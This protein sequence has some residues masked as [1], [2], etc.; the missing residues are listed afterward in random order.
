VGSPVQLNSREAVDVE[1]ERQQP[2]V[3]PDKPVVVIEASKAWVPLNL[4]NLWAYRELV[5][6]LMWRDVKVRY[7][8][9]ILGAAWAVMQPLITTLI[10][11]V[12]FGRWAGIPSDNV[13]YPMF[14]YS[15]LL[16]WTFFS[17]AVMSAGNSLIGNANLITKVYFPRMIIP[18]AA[19]GSGLVDLAIAFSIQI[20]LMVYYKVHLSWNIVLLPLIIL[21]MTLLAL[22]VGMW[23]AALN[24]KYRDVRYALPFVIQIWMFLTPIIYSASMI[25]EQWRWTLRLNPLASIIEA[26]RACLVGQPIRWI[27]LAAAAAASVVIVILA[28]YM[29][30]RMEKS[31]AELV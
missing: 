31:F 30:R 29:F 9:T 15:G 20:A 11:T 28:S 6:F 26:Y 27:A 3:L 2:L 4:L 12:L 16:A 21:M 23:T 14:V 25:P 17:N 24:V 22:G 18:A 19:V 13:P 7:K 1:R 5:Y 8:Q 10:F